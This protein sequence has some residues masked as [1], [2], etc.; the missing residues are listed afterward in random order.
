M[1]A[2]VERRPS[3]NGS[4]LAEKRSTKT[5][6]GLVSVIVFLLL[7]WIARPTGHPGLNVAADLLTYVCIGAAVFWIGRALVR[8][9]SR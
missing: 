9:A 2:K 1:N 4:V 8:R 7:V 5:W 6:E 3:R